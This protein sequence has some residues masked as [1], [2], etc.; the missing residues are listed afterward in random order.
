MHNFILF[1]SR[2]YAQYYSI[3]DTKLSVPKSKEFITE[4]EALKQLPKEAAVQ[5]IHSD[6]LSG[7]V[8]LERAEPGY[9]LRKINPNEVQIHCAS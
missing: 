7:A 9:S 3:I 4:V 1:S 2:L 8:L 5:I 6:L